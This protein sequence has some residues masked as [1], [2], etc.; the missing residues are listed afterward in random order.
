[1]GKAE[2]ADGRAGEIK[3]EVYRWREM[4]K[5]GRGVGRT[6]ESAPN[7]GN[8]NTVAPFAAAKREDLEV[9][10]LLCRGCHEDSGFRQPSAL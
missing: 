10:L 8:A 5:Y 2:R 4:H 1:M 3:K 7:T 9:R 6:T